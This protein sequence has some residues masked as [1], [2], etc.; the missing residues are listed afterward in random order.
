MKLA[1]AQAIAGAVDD[2]HL[3]SDYII[4]SVFDTTVSQKISESVKTA[5]Y[6]TGVAQSRQKK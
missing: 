1:A 4:P 3:N 2:A 5:A 6:K